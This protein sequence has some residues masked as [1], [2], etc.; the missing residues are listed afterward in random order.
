[1]DF[2]IGH[3]EH[4]LNKSVCDV[5]CSDIYRGVS[6][7]VI[8]EAH[9]VVTW[10]EEF[11]PHYKRLPKLRSIFPQAFVLALT[12]TATIQMQKDI[13]SC[14]QMNDAM[15][16]CRSIARDNIKLSVQN[17]PAATAQKITEIHDD[18]QHV[19]EPY[20]N[21]LCDTIENFPKTII[22]SKLKVCAF[23]YEMINREARKREDAQIIMASVAQYHAP[24]TEKVN[25]K[26]SKI[27]FV[28][29]GAILNELLL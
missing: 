26:I 4:V 3:P 28:M 7:I 1:M 27:Q 9:C 6:H 8:D 16:I 14:L 11:R 2:L 18:L 25:Y 24:S 19:L 13:L 10:G 29:T 23:A 21:E 17:R 15:T 20:V 5:L 22:Y 12:A